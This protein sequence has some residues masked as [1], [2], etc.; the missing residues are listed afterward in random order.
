MKKVLGLAEMSIPFFMLLGML[1][2][3]YDSKTRGLL[4]NK[5]RSFGN[6]LWIIPKNGEV[7]EY[8][9]VFIPKLSTK[10]FQNYSCRYKIALKYRFNKLIFS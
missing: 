1:I 10:L 3:F 7:L 4:E 6:L 8:D 2:P 5:S 9:R